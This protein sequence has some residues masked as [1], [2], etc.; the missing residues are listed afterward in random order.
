LSIAAS[1]LY[2]S[3][4]GGIMLAGE[5]LELLQ[6]KAKLNVAYKSLNNFFY[7]KAFR[8]LLSN[9]LNEEDADD[10][11]QETFIKV[12]EKIDTLK[13]DGKFE[14]WLWQILRNNMNEFYRKSNRKNDVMFS[15]ASEDLENLTGDEDVKVGHGQ[16]YDDQQSCIEEKFKLFKEEMP[17]RH[18]VINLQKEGVSIED[19]SIRIGR[20][21]AATKEFL[22]QSKKKLIPYFEECKDLETS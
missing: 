10:V 12:F 15:V 20:S 4:I 1:H 22:S 16:K 11:I 8:F 18:Y 2:K 5:V 3:K 14:S 19:V 13:E 21:Y 9:R 17:D 6:D 7:K